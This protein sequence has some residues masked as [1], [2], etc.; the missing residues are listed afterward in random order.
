MKE[1][2]IGVETS[3]DA[4]DVDQAEP[5]TT[6]TEATM[7]TWRSRIV[8]PPVIWAGLDPLGRPVDLDR[9]VEAQGLEEDS[10]SVLVLGNDRGVRMPHAGPALLAPDE[11]R[12]EL[13]G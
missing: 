13:G 12:V 7:V 9:A 11:C 3:Q 6:R 5:S 2:P 10:A 4:R 1:W 8:V